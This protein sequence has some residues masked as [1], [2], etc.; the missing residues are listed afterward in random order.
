MR[1]AVAVRLA[2]HARNADGV[3]QAVSDGTDNR[4]DSDYNI[5]PLS[6]IPFMV[7]GSY[8]FAREVVSLDCCDTG[9]GV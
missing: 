1:Q 3:L 6:R 2:G 9:A 4:A 8:F 7:F 5:E